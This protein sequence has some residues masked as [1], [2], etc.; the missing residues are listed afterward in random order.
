MPG[1]PEWKAERR[2][3]IGASEAA[4]ACGL[5]RYATPLHIY[6]RKIG[7]AP[8]LEETD[9]MRLGKRLEPVVVDEYQHRTGHVVERPCPM[10]RH[11]EHKWM[12][13]TPDGMVPE[14]AGLLECKTTTWRTASELG[15]DGSDYVPTDWLIQC[16]HQMA[17]MDCDRVDLAVLLDGRTLRVFQ[18]QA[19]LSLIDELIRAEEDLW[20]RILLRQPPEPDW[21]HPGTPELIRACQQVTGDV[22]ALPES[23]ASVLSEY[24]AA[25]DAEKAAKEKAELAKSKLIYAMAGAATASI[26]DVTLTRKTVERKSY[27]VPACSYVDF[28]VKTPKGAK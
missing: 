26:G 20:R 4:A 10:H 8:D 14:F 22:I 16:Q 6:Q 13:A 11:R 5:S 7:I 3:G 19:N 2:N 27:T 24:S 21:S 28:R 18:I 9:A 12:F 17:V 25:K 15:D 23:Y 1:T